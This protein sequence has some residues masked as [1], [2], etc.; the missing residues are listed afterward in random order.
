MNLSS[1]HYPWGMLHDSQWMPE[2]APNSLYRIEPGV[3]EDGAEDLLEVVTEEPTEKG[4]SELEQ[5]CAAEEETKEKETAGEERKKNP[6]EN[7]Q[8]ST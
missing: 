1:P 7:V 2:I 8:W 4:L 6:Q 5:E 3:E